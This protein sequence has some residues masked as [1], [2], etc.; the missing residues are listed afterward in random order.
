MGGTPR[1][2]SPNIPDSLEQQGRP[3]ASKSLSVMSGMSSSQIRTKAD[4]QARRGRLQKTSD[5][6]NMKEILTD[7]SR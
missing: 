6:S 3:Q 1:L 5:Q 7:E 2:G 4:S